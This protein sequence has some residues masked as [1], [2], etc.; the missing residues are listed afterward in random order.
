[1][2]RKKI[3]F[4]EAMEQLEEI[5]YKLESGSV[6]LEESVELYKKGSELA[7]ICRQ[8]LI[9]AEG[10]ILLLKKNAEDAGGIE[11]N[12]SEEFSEDKG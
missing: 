1:M 2:A 12:V 4:E 8:K 7:E 5:I 6:S 11:I 9:K 10:E 3:S